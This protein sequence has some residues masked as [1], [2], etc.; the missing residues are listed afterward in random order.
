[1]EKLR[2]SLSS[3]AE[4]L[5]TSEN[6]IK[7]ISSI[8]DNTSGKY[9]L[10]S[11]REAQEIRLKGVV[12]VPLLEKL[13]E[14]VQNRQIDNK[15]NALYRAIVDKC[16]YF[17]AYTTIVEV[18]Y[19]VSY[20]VGNAGVVKAT[21]EKMNVA[22]HDEIVSQREYYQSKADFYCIELQDFLLNNRS[23]I[24]ELSEAQTGRIK[25]NLYSAA[26]CGIFLGGARGKRR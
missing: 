8:S 25:S 6:F 21:D 19:K 22:N 4:V 23:E 11:L 3:M 26:S 16:Q 10:P 20:K 24:A 1:M 12:G 7:S 18:M 9:I 15:E 14:L 13:K 17:L 5:L 2:K